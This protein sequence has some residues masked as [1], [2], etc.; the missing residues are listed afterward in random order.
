MLPDQ[1][2]HRARQEKLHQLPDRAGPQPAGAGLSARRVVSGHRETRPLEAAIDTILD[3]MRDLTTPR[4]SRPATPPLTNHVPEQAITHR[5][6]GQ[7]AETPPNADSLERFYVT[8]IL[9]LDKCR[10]TN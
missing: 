10:P 9:R 5:N 3:W 1:Q 8:A 6:I 7:N 4:R 2:E